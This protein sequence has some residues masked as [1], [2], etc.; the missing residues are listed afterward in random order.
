MPTYVNL[1]REDEN[2]LYT[3]DHLF[4]CIYDVSRGGL[5]SNKGDISEEELRT[6]RRVVDIFLRAREIEIVK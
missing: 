6:A 1:S 4:D 5:K 3:V 2:A